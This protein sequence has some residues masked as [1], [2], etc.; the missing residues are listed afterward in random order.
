MRLQTLAW[1]LVLVSSL[2]A[3]RSSGSEDSGRESWTPLFDGRTLDGWVTKGGRYD[4]NAAWSVEDGV[5]TGREGPDG[6]GGLLYTSRSYQDFELEV[7]VRLTYPFDSGVFVRMLPRASGVRGAQVTID[8]RPGGEVGAIY[9][10][11][12]LAHNETAA[13]EMRK[14]EWNSFRVRCA[15]NPMH[16]QAWM[17]GDEISD[18]QLESAEGFAAAGL[19]GLQVHGGEN[20][21]EDAMVQFRNV[22]VRR[23]P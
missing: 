5:I 15:G 20:P 13:A 8:H 4:G 3:C 19:I 2:G 18:F 21:P 10:D 16:I 22:R 14:N 1:T 11:G 23:I 17:N 12:F 9:S 7:D 6:A